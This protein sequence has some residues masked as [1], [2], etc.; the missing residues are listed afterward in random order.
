MA[1]TDSQKAAGMDSQKVAETDSQMEAEKAAERAAD[2]EQDTSCHT[3]NCRNT[4]M[5]GRSP[6]STSH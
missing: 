3:S 5:R 1:E 4:T 6:K 2:S